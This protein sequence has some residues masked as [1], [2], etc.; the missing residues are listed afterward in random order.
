MLGPIVDVIR[1]LGAV[2]E[3]DRDE[4]VDE[5]IVLPGPVDREL[6]LFRRH[7][8]EVAI[9]LV[10]RG[11]QEQLDQRPACALAEPANEPFRLVVAR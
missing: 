5:R 11:P 6:D 3:A 1:A 9:W 10:L 8:G 4:L 7:A 2:E